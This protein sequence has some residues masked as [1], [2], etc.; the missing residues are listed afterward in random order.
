VIK[1]GSCIASVKR[2]RIRLNLK[3][4]EITMIATEKVINEKFT[5]ADLALM[6]DDGK[7]REIIESP[8]LPGF[9]CQVKLFFFLLP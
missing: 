8:L 6:P 1:T 3:E 4:E 9:S 7:R 5:S 2:S